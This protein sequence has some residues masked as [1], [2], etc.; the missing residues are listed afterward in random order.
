MDYMENNA[1]N[2]LKVNSTFFELH[3]VL[4]KNINSKN[5]ALLLRRQQSSSRWE[6]KSFENEKL[7]D[8]IK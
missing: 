2:H 1:K 6:C 7:N 8:K 4:K 5:V 3:S